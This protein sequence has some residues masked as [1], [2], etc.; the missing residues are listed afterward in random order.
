MDFTRTE[1]KKESE[2]VFLVV[3]YCNDKN[4]LVW[5]FLLGEAYNLLNDPIKSIFR[6][7]LYLKTSLKSMVSKFV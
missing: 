3:G 2:L 1:I 5:L 4:I 7:W 6:K